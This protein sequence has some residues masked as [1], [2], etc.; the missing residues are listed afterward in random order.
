MIKPQLRSKEDSENEIEK[1]DELED[2]DNGDNDSNSSEIVDWYQHNN[3]IFLFSVVLFLYTI[4]DFF[5][6]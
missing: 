5:W 3:V 2:H 6:L 1:I 4:C